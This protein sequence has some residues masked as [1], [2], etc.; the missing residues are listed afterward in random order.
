LRI[1]FIGDISASS[2]RRA[3]S[4]ILPDLRDRYDLD[5][6]IANGENAAGGLGITQPTAHELFNTGID[7]ITL[8]NHAFS[9]KDALEYVAKEAHLLRPA[10]FPPGN[11][12]KGWDVF[13]TEEGNP[14][15]VI[16][17]IGRTFMNPADDPFR[18]ADQII[19]EASEKTDVII[20]DMHAEA[21]SEKMALGWY[22]NGRVSAVVGTHTHI[23]TSDE[24]V[25][26]EGTAYITDVGMTGVHDSVLGLDKDMVIQRF[27]TGL[28]GK[29]TL[30]EGKAT[31]QSVLIEIDPVNGLAES[32]KRINI[33]E[34]D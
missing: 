34:D 9:K 29:F 7:V 33:S 19:S 6:V 12:G 10:N 31:L 24:R 13:Y 15:A 25:L 14:I 1:L 22:L 8:G 18:T 4:K 27:K 17:L 5:F 26:S 32:I 2:G 28:L 23:Q 30:A 21:T 11:P 20:V 3:I 16:N